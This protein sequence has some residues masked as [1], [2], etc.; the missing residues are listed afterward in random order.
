MTAHI[1]SEAAHHV[2]VAQQQGRMTKPAMAATMQTTRLK[3]EPGQNGAHDD[4]I[5]TKKYG[6]SGWGAADPLAT[7]NAKPTMPANSQKSRLPNNSDN[8]P[9]T[10][11][12]AASSKGVSAI[13]LLSS[14]L[15]QS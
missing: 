3:C 10:I 1:Y 6:V 7:I 12:T 11:N 8:R 2:Q 4:A 5:I 9:N 15:I 13:A 14:R